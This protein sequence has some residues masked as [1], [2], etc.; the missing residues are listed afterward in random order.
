MPEFTITDHDIRLALSTVGAFAAGMAYFQDRRT[1]ILD[2]DET[3]GELRI[4]AETQGSGRQWYTQAI[5]VYRRSNGVVRIEGGCSCPVGHNCKHVAAAVMQWRSLGTEAVAAALPPQVE[6]WLE[7]VESVAKRVGESYPPEL[8][9][10]LLYVLRQDPERQALFVSPVSVRLDKAGGVSG[11]GK[12]YDAA[13][14]RSGAPAKFLRASDLD[15]LNRIALWRIYGLG[16]D[17]YALKGNEGA[18]VL[19]AIVATG[20]A[21]WERVEGP[22]L[23]PGPARAGKPSWRVGQDGSQTFSFAVEALPEAVILPLAPPHY[24]DLPNGHV[25]RVQTDMPD[26]LSATLLGAPALPPD[27]AEIAADRLSAALDGKLQAF[28]LPQPIPAAETKK[29]R[30]S[31]H[32]RLTLTEVLRDLQPPVLPGY[33]PYRSYGWGATLVELPVAELTFD[34]EVCRFA[35]GQAERTATR[36]EQGRLLRIERD[37]SAEAALTGRLGPMG[38]RKLADIKGLRAHDDNAGA[39]SFAADSAPED[40]IGLILGHRSELEAEGWAVEIDPRFPLNLAAVDPAPWTF[41]LAPTSSRGSGIDWFDARLG[42]RIDGA[43]ITS[44]RHWLGF[45]AGCRTEEVWKPSGRGW[46]TRGWRG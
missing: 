34:Y 3:G 16:Q 17:G 30:P 10:R 6:A 24:V 41:D 14:A 35:P 4:E 42:V 19:G 2:I 26:A 40:F 31:P 37:L 1:Q 46:Q 23:S 33:S 21:V 27:A 5:R 32:L 12:V 9:Q 43:E 45:Y 28:A 25:G 36:Y 29:P 20:R 38:L 18:S 11:A 22:S 8:R 15:I 13:N 39:F 44:C 7:R